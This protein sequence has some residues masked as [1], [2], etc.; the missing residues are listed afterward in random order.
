MRKRL[1]VDDD[2]VVELYVQILV[3]RQ[4]H[5][6]NLESIFKF[7]DDAFSF[8]RL[9]KRVKKLATGEFIYA[10]TR[11]P[12]D[13]QRD[14]WDTNIT[15][16]YASREDRETEERSSTKYPRTMTPFQTIFK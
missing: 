12:K 10:F 1:G 4:Q 6:F 9:E 8:E 13:K 14:A 2:D 5:A 15:T 16:S 7:D 11:F 3:D